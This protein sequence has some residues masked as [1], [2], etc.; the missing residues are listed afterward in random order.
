MKPLAP[1]LCPSAQPDLPDARAFAVVD[2]EPDAPRRLTWIEKP[3]PVTP[4]LLALTGD[5]PPTE[6]MRFA[7]RCQEKSCSHF[8][9]RDCR[10]AS[11]I[12]A[13][14]DPVVSSLPHCAIR[15]DCR[16]YRQEGAAACARCPQ[17]VTRTVDPSELLVRTATPESRDEF[18]RETETR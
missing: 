16:W 6:V 8:D 13:M 2:G 5:A 11:R 1:P 15:A 12:V 7:A 9:G 18:L 4:E 14:I 10:L 17:I 3:V